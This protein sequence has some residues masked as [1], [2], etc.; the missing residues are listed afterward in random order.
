MDN[1]I[2]E[3]EIEIAN[4]EAR[5][6]EIWGAMDPERYELSQVSHIP[7]VVELENNK[8]L[9]RALATEALRI[10]KVGNN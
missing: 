8:H 6:A 1:A 5:N 3:I 2:K 9:I 7:E 10:L 4:L